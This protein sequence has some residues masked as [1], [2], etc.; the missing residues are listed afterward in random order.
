MAKTKDRII[1]LLLLLFLIGVILVGIKTGFY[2]PCLDVK[3]FWI[4]SGKC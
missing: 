1:T 2:D 3:E 4:Y